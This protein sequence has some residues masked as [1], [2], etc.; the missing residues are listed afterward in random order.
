MILT[1][2]LAYKTSFKANY[3]QVEF[4]LTSVMNKEL[5]EHPFDG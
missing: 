2:L 4:S 1:K 5:N 3:V